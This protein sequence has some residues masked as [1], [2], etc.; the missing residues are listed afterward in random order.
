MEIFHLHDSPFATSYGRSDHSVDYFVS[1][2]LKGGG[3]INF[4]REISV[5]ETKCMSKGDGYCEFVIK[6]KNKL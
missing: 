1:G 6:A 4:N 3:E 5:N 2:F